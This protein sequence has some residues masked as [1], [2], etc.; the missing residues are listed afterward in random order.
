MS[1]LTGMEPGTLEKTL[2]LDFKDGGKYRPDGPGGMRYPEWK[3]KMEAALP[4]FLYWLLNSYKLPAALFDSR[5]G[6]R[7]TN[8]TYAS[9]LAAPTLEADNIETQEIVRVAVFSERKKDDE[10]GEVKII[11]T[12][13]LSSGEVYDLIY[14]FDNPSRLRAAQ[15]PELRNSKAIAGLF[16]KWLG[17]AA[18]GEWVNL[19][20]FQLRWRKERTSYT[21][22]DFHQP[23]GDVAWKLGLEKSVKSGIASE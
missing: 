14:A 2:I 8:P 7:Y 20:R 12:T 6:V 4:Y 10:E 18:E 9:E 22:Y 16:R 17:K 23:L 21:V 13:G 1:I 15:Y 19:Y 5:Y 11:K 3:E